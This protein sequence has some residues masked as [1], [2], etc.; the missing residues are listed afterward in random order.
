MYQLDIQLH[1]YLKKTFLNDVE[2]DE[3]LTKKTFEGDVGMHNTNLFE[4]NLCQSNSDEMNEEIFCEW[5]NQLETSLP[6]FWESIYE[7]ENHSLNRTEKIFKDYIDTMFN[8]K[9]EVIINRMTSLH[10]MLFNNNFLK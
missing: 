3:F 7:T 8:K 5:K 2:L 9:T 10:D 4:K 1:R 6:I